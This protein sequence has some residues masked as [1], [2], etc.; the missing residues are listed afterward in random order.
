M[1]TKKQIVD[2]IAKFVADDPVIAEYI[3]AKIEQERPG[4]YAVLGDETK[5]DT[6]E[7]NATYGRIAEIQMSLMAEA[8]ATMSPVKDGA[9]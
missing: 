9:N 2:R 3:Q 6:L 8:T 5:E 4:A 7:Y 1:L